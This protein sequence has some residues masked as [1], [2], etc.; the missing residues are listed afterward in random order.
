MIS[1]VTL[2]VAEAASDPA[3]DRKID[4]LFQTLGPDTPGAVVLVARAGKVEFCKAYGSADP[5]SHMLMTADTRFRIGS[6]TKQ[7]TAAAI[8]KLQEQG[9]LS[10]E[11]KLSRYFPGWP[12]SDEISLYHLLTHTSGI[13]D[14]T[15][16]PDFAAQITQ[17]ITLEKLVRSFEN[18]PNDFDPG[19]L[20]EYNNSGYVLLAAIIEKISGESYDAFLQQTFFGPLG[21]THTGVERAETSSDFK[22]RGYAFGSGAA[23]PAEVWN[24]ERL[25]GAGSLISNA[26]DLFLWNEGIFGGKVLSKETLKSAWTVGLVEGDDPTHPEETGY[27]FGWTIDHLGSEREISHGG[28][29][30]GFGS[31]LLRLPD[32]KVTVIVLLNCVL[33]MP[34]LHQWNLARSI[35]QLAIGTSRPEET[36]Y[37]LSSDDAELI[38]GNYNMG[39]QMIL[40]VT[41][42]GPRVFFHINDRP[43]T[44]LL[45]R[46]DRRFIAGNG[47]AEATFVRN[48]GGQVVKAIL[49]QAGG[50]IDAP[51]V[52]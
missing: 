12:K 4:A 25:K 26:G 52:P 17:P 30:A 16:K 27:G 22:A 21:M 39:H 49:K 6:L 3:L 43:A 28:E 50:R 19:K 23:H 31:Y 1:A 34:G 29:L 11:D 2:N 13:H 35:A 7:F 51:K 24:L 5:E 14:Y 42:K 33:Q 15:K 46:S 20:F 38:V 40:S 41:C 8:L 10:V 36:P 18:D 44:E 47:E 32:L 37:T 45:A 48:T 9:K